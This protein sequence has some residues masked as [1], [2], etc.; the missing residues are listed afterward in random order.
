KTTDIPS[1][2]ILRFGEKHN[3]WEMGNT[4]PCG[5]C[6]EIHYYIG[7]TPEKQDIKKINAGDPEYIELWNLV[8]IQYDR[9]KNGILHNLPARHVDTGAGLERIVAALQCKRSN[10]DTDL[11]TPLIKKISEITGFKYSEENGIAH[12]VIADH[13]R[14]LTFSIAEGGMPSNEGR[15]YVIRRV[16]RRAARFG[17]MLNMHIPF[18]FQLV[19]PLTEIYGDIYPEILERK[20]HIQKVIKNEEE[21]FSEIL[22]RGLELFSIVTEKLESENRKVIPG[23]DVF[24]LYDTYGFPFDLTAL[25]AE[26]K[27]F[28]IDENGFFSEMEKQRKRARSVVSFQM[29]KKYSIDK[30]TIMTEGNDSEFVGYEFEDSKATIRRYLIDGDKIQ[31][32]LDKTPFYAE[33]GGQVGDTGTITGK[34]FSINI[35]NTFKSND[36]IIHSGVFKKGKIRNNPEAFA[37][38]DKERRQK[39]KLNHT[40]THLL[41]SALRK[42][43]GAHVHQSGSLVSP[44][45]LRFDLTHFLKMS[46]E[47]LKEVEDI[48]NRKIREN[49][50]VAI[51]NKDYEEAKKSGA[52][53]LFGEKYSD[54]VRVVTIDDY[55]KE[56]CGGTH[57]KRTGDIGYFKII[58]E[59][60]VASGIRRIEA[61]TGEAAIEEAMRCEKI[62]S[63]LEKI[64]N[65]S[66]DKLEDKV[67]RLVKDI[68]TLNKE[69]EKQSKIGL[70]F[71]I[72]EEINNSPS[73]GE[74]KIFTQQF[75]SK[76]IDEL[77]RIGDIV[78]S[79]LNEGVGVLATVNK[80]KPLI[81][82]VVADST[83]RK[84]GIKAGD[85]VKTLGKILGGGGGGR[86]HMATAGGKYPEKI[87]EV[88]EK[89]YQLIKDKI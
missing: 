45:R 31:I 37:E 44:Q 7:N 51:Q 2:R 60:S 25:L 3:F 81:T 52:M 19:E 74:L 58:S 47:E 50:K 35:E 59:S 46:S 88:F 68:K 57:V 79:N 63:N 53:A 1:K 77:K 86:P 16:L 26:E 32:I 89:I 42:V 71:Q 65:V 24:K 72:K 66:R 17:R 40:A 9:D 76:S 11:F 62:V 30:W 13:V 83:I 18:I 70:E 56:L 27:G 67:E 5:P 6:S 15:G 69:L 80:N 39:I 84:Y 34:D 82:V 64:T 28:N 54:I 55:S 85:L 78:R 49:I 75:D 8:F 48:V 43:L 23:H 21:S 41:H 61:V 22:D 20:I 12:R 33:S 14:M 29:N 36:S 10:Y 4:G 73:V 87:P 38:I